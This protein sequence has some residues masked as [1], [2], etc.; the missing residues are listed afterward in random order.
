M[1]PEQA[2]RGAEPPPSVFDRTRLAVTGS[3]VILYLVVVT[4]LLVMPAFRHQL[5]S[6]DEAQGSPATTQ[7]GAPSSGPP[8]RTS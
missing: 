3:F 2:Q 6:E 8:A 4:Y 7:T 5:L 1:P